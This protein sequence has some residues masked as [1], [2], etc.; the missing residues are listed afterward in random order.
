MGCLQVILSGIL[1][2]L[3][4]VGVLYAIFFLIMSGGFIFTGVGIPTGIIG[5]IIVIVLVVLGYL[6]LSWLWSLIEKL[7]GNFPSLP[8]QPKYDNPYEH[9]LAGAKLAELDRAQRLGYKG[10][11]E[12]RKDGWKKQFRS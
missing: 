4:L 8:P 11:D 9:P 1:I 5:V 10:V 7:P 6:L 2:L 12:A 3:A